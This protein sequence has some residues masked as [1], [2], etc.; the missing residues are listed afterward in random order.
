MLATSMSLRSSLP[1]RGARVL[2]RSLPALFGAAVWPYLVLV[3]IYA[4]LHVVVRHLQP[5]G[6][7]PF[8][9]TTAWQGMSFPAQLGLFIGF[10][11]IV[12]VPQ[13]F[14][15]GGV[16]LLVF[17][18]CC[19][20]T[21]S[22]K[23]ALKRLLGRSPSLLILSF[24]IGC[25]VVFGSIPLVLPG[26]I[27]LMLTVF[28]VPVMLLEQAG[29]VIAL[30]RSMHLVRERIGTV[31][32]LLVAFGVVGQVTVLSFVWLTATLNLSDMEDLVTMWAFIGLILPALVCVYGTVVTILYHDIRVSHGELQAANATQQ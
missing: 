14:A 21:M 22:L 23:D 18:D 19:G 27:V 12:F 3:S 2:G 31:I 7:P 32:E 10:A 20:E 25:G 26:L 1:V 24:L 9:P 17:D 6:A 11:A 5:E 13:G 16:S 29:V 15:L 28:A 4:V 8:D 30:R